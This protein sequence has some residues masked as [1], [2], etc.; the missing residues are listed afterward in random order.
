[1]L[2]QEQSAIAQRFAGHPAKRFGSDLIEI[3]G[4]PAVA[5]AA[6]WL[7]CCPERVVS[8]G[9]H[10]VI[11]ASIRDAQIGHR[12]PLVYWQREYGAVV[13]ASMEPTRARVR[14]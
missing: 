5:D 7:V 11:I 6:C 4:L 8:A 12:Q 10:S 9:D 14:A 2:A 1:M 13:R 3:D